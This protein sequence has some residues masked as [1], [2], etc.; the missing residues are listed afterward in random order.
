MQR[1]RELGWIEGR[2][3]QIEYRWAEGRFDRSPEMIAE[4]LALKAEIIVTHAPLNV[5]AARRVTSVIPIVFAAVGDP[6]GIGVVAS[7]ARPGGNVTGLSLQSADLAGK[8]LELLREII[9]GRRRL[10]I[11][12]NAASPN[13]ALE[14]SEVKAANPKFDFEVTVLEIK[15]A[16]DIAPAIGGLKL[17]A[18]ALYVQTDPLFNTNRSRISALALDARLPT[19]SGT[20]EYV[21]AGSLMSY[22]ANFTDLFRRAGDYVDKILRGANASDLPVQ[23]PTKFDLIVNLK[24]AKALGLELPPTLLAR[25]DEVIE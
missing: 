23:Q 7:L 8:R 1:L 14:V 16:E 15:R 6:V 4:L 24:T 9:P 11:L 25:A 10:A 3:L 5:I 22:G 21:E 18:D 12:I 19:I 20:R 2:N 17:G 13:A